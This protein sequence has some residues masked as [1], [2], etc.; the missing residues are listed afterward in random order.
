MFS[1]NRNPSA[2]IFPAPRSQS[3]LTALFVAL[4][5][6]AAFGTPLTRAQEVRKPPKGGVADLSSIGPQTHKGDVTIAEDA[7]DIHYGNQRLRADHVEYNDQTNEAYARGHIIFDYE[8]QHIEAEEA[9]YNVSTGRGT[10]TNVRGF[11]R[12]DR[13]PN[14]SVLLTDNPLYF[15]AKNVEKYNTDLYILSSAWITVCDPEHPR[16]QFFAQHARIKVDK[17]A[18]LVNVNF[19]LLRVPLIWLPYATAPAGEKVRQSGFLLPVVGNSSSKGFVFG[20]AFYWAPNPWMDATLGAELLS[21]RGSAERGHFRAKP[22]ENTSINYTYF[23]VIDR[24]VPTVIN[25]GLPD[26]TT[27]LVSQGGHEQRLEVISDLKNNWRFVTD[28][29]ELSS[30]TFRLAFADNFGDAINSEVRSSIFLTHNFDGYSFDVAALNDNSFLTVNPVQTSVSLRNAPEVRFGSVDR[31]PWANLPFYFSFDAFAGA[32]HRNDGVID[33]PAAVPRLEFA[34][35]MTVPFHFGQWL[36]VTATAAFRTAYYGDSLVP[37][38]ILTTPILSPD[39]IT[40]NDGEFSLDFRLPVVQRYFQKPGSKKKYKHTIEPYFAYNYVTGINNFQQL[41]RFDSDSTLTDTNELE[42]GVTQ[43][44]FV[45]NGDDQ[46]QELIT[47]SL[48]QKHFFD[49]TFGGALVT[50]ARNVFETLDDISPFAFA[51]APRNWSPLISDFK[52][53]PGGPFDF[54]QILEYDTQRGNSGQL[55]TIGTLAKFKPYKEF[56]A[57]IAD[58]RL[59]ADPLV[60][61]PK[62]NQIRTLI[63]Y[64]SDTK[65]GFNIT[66]GVSY[67]ITNHALQNQLVQIGYN[68]GCCG[69]ALEYRRLELGQVRTDNQFKVAFVIA[70]I[71]NF[72]NLRRQEKIF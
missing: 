41:I 2:R 19:R 71:G 33:T 18:A 40:R 34:P 5:L 45:K 10:F 65:K 42:Y 15:E 47:W 63:G 9:H 37:G 62:S 11:V 24:G 50:G 52:I 64:G 44:L 70:N 55:T 4:A 12:I 57:T 68:G 6:L 3:L 48:V 67:D 46:P 23:G 1:V 53:T 8:N 27:Q 69:L 31:A 26:Q 14:P 72:G 7:V 32:L 30:L 39:S 49:P 29:N 21:R 54:E 22:W 28:W 20:D 38:S 16:W 51:D 66:T 56:F 43:R 59:D 13:K 36:D 17:T 60:L 25:P 58:F 61:Q 35:R